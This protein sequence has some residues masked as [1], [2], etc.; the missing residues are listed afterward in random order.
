MPSLRIA[1]VISSG[2]LAWVLYRRDAPV[3]LWIY[4][5]FAAYSAAA[6]QPFHAD[7]WTKIWLWAEPTRMILRTIVSITLFLDIKYFRPVIARVSVLIAVAFC[8]LYQVTCGPDGLSRFM[9]A[10]T[11][12]LV[13]LWMFLFS[14]VLCLWRIG[15]EIPLRLGFWTGG[16]F[17]YAASAVIDWRITSKDLWMLNTDAWSMAL[18]VI[19]SVWMVKECLKPN[20]YHKGQYPLHDNG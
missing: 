8:L 16:L 6:F 5:L 12:W 20:Q 15:E 3:I 10:R 17:C 2:L 1:I 9:A 7:W 18:W 19:I 11:Y 4:F 14:A 13:F